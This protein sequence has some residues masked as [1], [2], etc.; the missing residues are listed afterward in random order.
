[1]L[2]LSL[3]WPAAELAGWASGPVWV[4]TAGWF[5]TPWWLPLLTHLAFSFPGTS[6]HTTGA[7]R[8]V[9]GT[10]V[11]TATY[12]VAS[13]AIYDPFFDVDCWRTCAE[14]PFVVNNQPELWE[15][16]GA[17]VRARRSSSPS[18]RR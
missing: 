4:Q 3:T 10:Y 1:M 5:L 15:R 14:S 7:R 8:I 13:V 2:G 16:V 11:A 18:V 17:R 9:I 6:L 12:A